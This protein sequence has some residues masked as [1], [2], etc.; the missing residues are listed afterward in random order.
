MYISVWDTPPKGNIER[1]FP[2]SI[3]HPNGERAV[4]IQSEEKLC[5]G[6]IGSG[7]K[8][9]ISE[10]EGMGHGQFYVLG[11]KNYE[12]HP[13]EK[14]FALAD[15]QTSMKASIEKE[16]TGEKDNLEPIFSRAADA[17]LIYVVKK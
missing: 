9:T 2:N 6:S 10:Y 15:W 12:Q 16:G 5:I 17:R 13:G 11:T 1:L 7:Y 4:L 8:V 3:S 14:D